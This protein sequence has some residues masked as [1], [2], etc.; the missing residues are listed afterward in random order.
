M[1]L[2]MQL[3]SP[4]NSTGSVC[5]KMDSLT[6]LVI[7]AWPQ[8][9]DRLVYFYMIVEVFQKRK[10]RNCTAKSSLWGSKR[11]YNLYPKPSF[12]WLSIPIMSWN[13]S[14]G[15][16]TVDRIEKRADLGIWPGLR[17][18]L[19]YLLLAVHPWANHFSSLNLSFLLCEMVSVP[20][21]Q[22]SI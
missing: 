21:P 5:Y 4:G 12:V 22:K 9:L 19:C 16:Q 13:W 18:Q 6:C 7:S 10:S 1:G 3:Q 14:K 8:V 20:N 15:Q 11:L 2:L 17:S